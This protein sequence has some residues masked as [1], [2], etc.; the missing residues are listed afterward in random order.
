MDARGVL[1]AIA[2][3]KAAWKIKPPSLP[4]CGGRRVHPK[5]RHLYF[6]VLLALM[7]STTS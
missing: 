3:S 1:D 5:S 7:R 4:R 6:T 2:A